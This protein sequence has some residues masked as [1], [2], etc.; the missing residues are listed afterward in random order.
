MHCV[1]LYDISVNAS[2]GMKHVEFCCEAV[3]NLKELMTRGF[4]CVTS[5][6]E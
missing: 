1:I 3:Y 4:F 2:V 5:E 6:Q